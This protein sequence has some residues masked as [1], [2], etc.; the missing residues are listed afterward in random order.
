M[1]AALDERIE[2]LKQIFV[3]EDGDVGKRHEEALAALRET[4][5]RRLSDCET[6]LN[7]LHDERRNLQRQYERLRLQK[8]GFGF[9]VVLLTGVFAGALGFAT[10]FAGAFLKNDTRRNF[11]AFSRQHAMDLELY[12]TRRDFASARDL[13][14]TA[15]KLP[16]W[17]PILPQ[18]EMLGRTVQHAEHCCDKK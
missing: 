5:G 6:Q 11:E 3:Q 1:F 13:I 17:K 16:E 10:G 4:Y 8:G 15:Q 2:K 14:L 12:M 9:R 18:L 7:A